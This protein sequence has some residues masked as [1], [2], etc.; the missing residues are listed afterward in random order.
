VSLGRNAKSHVVDVDVS[1]EG[2]ST[3]VSR[4]QGTIRMRNTGD[5]VLLNEGK[6]PIFVDG[7]PVLTGNKHRL[8]NNSVL[9]VC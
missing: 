5:F 8:N 7:R 2:P 1:L 9:E 4:K 6:R 3:K